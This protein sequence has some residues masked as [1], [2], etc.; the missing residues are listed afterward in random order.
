MNNLI[1]S[2]AVLTPFHSVFKY[3]QVL[4]A[5]ARICL[6]CACLS[7][8]ICS[9]W[10]VGNSIPFISH[11]SKYVNLFL[12]CIFPSLISPSPSPSFPRLFLSYFSSYLIFFLLNSFFNFSDKE[13]PR[14]VFVSNSRT[15][16]PS[17]IRILG[18]FR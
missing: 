5:E 15:C 17:S 12:R 7:E 10:R 8:R 1:F 2:T 14:S 4:Y 3:A 6:S 11:F 13:H 18:L 16:L 9:V